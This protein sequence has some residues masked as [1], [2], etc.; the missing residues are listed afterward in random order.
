MKTSN[1]ERP[2]I[3]LFSNLVVG[4]RGG[5]DNRQDFIFVKANDP[6][7]NCKLHDVDTTLAAFEPCHKR[8]VA[9]E[10]LSQLLLAETRILTCINQRTDERQLA[11]CSDCFRH[12]SHTF[13][14]VASG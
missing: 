3:S 5:F 11:I 10:L 8:L 7:Q 12:A 2:K 13:C 4:L 6:R 14:D 1:T 9:F